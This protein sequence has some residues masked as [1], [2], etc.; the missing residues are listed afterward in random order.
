MDHFQFNWKTWS[1]SEFV[2]AARCL[3][4]MVGWSGTF[5]SHASKLNLKVSTVQPSKSL[6][7]LGRRLNNLPP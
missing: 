1:I 7:F 5:M 3:P 6:S 4:D 2:I